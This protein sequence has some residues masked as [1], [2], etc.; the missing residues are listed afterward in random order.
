VEWSGVRLC[1][2]LKINDIR[3]V[4]YGYVLHAEK[5]IFIGWSGP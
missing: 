3:G 4:D 2:V 5:M 1:S